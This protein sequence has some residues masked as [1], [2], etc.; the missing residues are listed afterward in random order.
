[1]RHVLA[2]QMVW[3]RRR[4]ASRFH[5]STKSDSKSKYSKKRVRL[6]LSNAQRVSITFFT[7]LLIFSIFLVEHFFVTI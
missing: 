2:I 6:R 5:Q 7:F 4:S 1:M 3:E